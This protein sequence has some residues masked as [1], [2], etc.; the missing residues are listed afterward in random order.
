MNSDETGFTQ[1]NGDGKTSKRV[2]MG[3]VTPLVSFLRYTIAFPDTAKSLIGTGFKG[4]V[5]SDPW[6][7]VKFAGRI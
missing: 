5:T 1:H 4:T 6:S 7:N 2:A 3:M